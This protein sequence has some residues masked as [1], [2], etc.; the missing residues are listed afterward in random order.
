M[1]S[2]T[3]YKEKTTYIN[4]HGELDV[5]KHQLYVPIILN[6]KFVYVCGNPH[7]INFSLPIMTMSTRRMSLIHKALADAATQWKVPRRLGLM[8]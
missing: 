6:K 8:K 2:L 5:H 3:S 7:S 4:Y 1:S